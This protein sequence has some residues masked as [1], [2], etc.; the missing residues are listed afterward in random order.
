M[1]LQEP[2]GYFDGYLNVDNRIP[3]KYRVEK[4]RFSRDLYGELR[5][6]DGVHEVHAHIG[7]IAPL[8]KTGCLIGV[9]EVIIGGDVGKRFLT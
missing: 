5:A 2:E 7:L 4:S 9:D 8:L 3:P 1:R 6:A